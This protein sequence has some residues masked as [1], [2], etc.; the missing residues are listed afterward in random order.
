ML[1][2]KVNNYIKENGQKV[3]SHERKLPK[4]QKVDG[5]VKKNGTVVDS[6]KRIKSKK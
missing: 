6:Y 3:N 2:V 4:S 5:Y 1:K